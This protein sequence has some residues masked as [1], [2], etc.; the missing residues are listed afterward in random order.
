MITID[1]DRSWIGLV[2]QKQNQADVTDGKINKQE[3]HVRNT[4]DIQLVDLLALV[5]NSPE[6]II[7][8]ERL[9]QIRMEIHSNTYS[10]DFDSLVDN[11]LVSDYGQ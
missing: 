3:G 10:M 11:I 4:N 2:R 8:S 6:V 5:K 9:N 7:H 1:N